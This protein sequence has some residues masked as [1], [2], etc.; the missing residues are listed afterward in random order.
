MRRVGALIFSGFELLDLF[1]PLEM[2]GL[3]SDR[4]DLQLVAETLDPVTSNQQVRSQ[5][6]RTFSDAGGFDILLVPGGSGTRQEVSNTPLLEWI[7][8]ATTEAEYVLSVCTGSLLLAGAGVLDGRRAT[9]NKAAFEKIAAQGPNVNWIREARWVE[10]GKFLTSSGVSAGMD[11]SL[12]AI[13]IMHGQE[14][15]EKVAVWSEYDWHQDPT[16]D[17]FAKIHGLV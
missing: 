10:D 17:P 5:P 3:L 7:R 16:W 6:D 14:T 2:F 9:T 15:A 13:A 8:T 12:R 1:G 11:M 4:F